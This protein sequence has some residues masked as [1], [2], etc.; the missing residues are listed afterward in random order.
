MLREGTARRSESSWS[1]ALHVVPKKDNGWRP[2]GNYRARNARTIPDR[3]PVHHIHHYSHQL[4]GCSVFS[5][6]DL[7]RAYNQ[8]PVHPDIQKTAITTPFG[9]FEFPFMSFGLRNAA[10]TFQRIMDDI[11]RGLDFC[12]AYLDV[13]LVFSRSLEEQ[14][15]HLRTLFDQFQRYGILINPVKCVFRASEVTFLGYKVSA[16]GSQPLEERVTHLQEYQPPKTASQLWRFLGM[17]NFYRRFLPHAAATQAP[18]HGILSGPRVKG[19]HPITWTPELLKAFDECKA[20]LSRATLLGHPDP[21]APLAHVTDVSTSA[22][23]AVLQQQVKNAWQPLAFIF[24]KLNPAQQKYS[25]Y[26]RELLA[27]YEAVKHFRHTLE[28]RHYIIFTDHKPITYAFQQKRDTCSPRQFNYLDFVSSSRQTYETSLDRTTLS[29]TPSLA[30]RLSLRHHPTTHWPHYR[31][32][33]TNSEHSWGPPLP[34]GSR[35]YQ[36]PVPRCPSAVI[37]LP[38]NLGCKFQLHFGSRCSSPST[39]CRI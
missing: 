22:M 36:S 28:A 34:Y 9:L 13:I 16:E 23:G 25:T 10:Q 19:S 35:N 14:E 15:N 6:I 39:I 31:T 38:G 18:L 2:C 5:K 11:L 24:K 12:F 17:L 21:S 7:V 1:S 32:A 29:P 8:I 4:F 20:S 30:S 33:T 3:Y 37:P 27:I 26:D